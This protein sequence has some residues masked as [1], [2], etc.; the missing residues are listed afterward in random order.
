MSATFSRPLRLLSVTALSVAVTLLLPFL[1]HLI[2]SSGVPLGA[3]LLP[4]FFAPFLAAMLFH[5]AVSLITA[6]ATPALNHLLTGRPSPE[7]AGLLS[8][9]L[10]LFVGFVLLGKRLGWRTFLLAPL[11]YVGSSTL[12]YA[13]TKLFGNAEPWVSR[14]DALQIALPGLICLAILNALVLRFERPS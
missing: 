13:L 4:I 2:P 12:V 3:R 14:L 6:A 9:E 7:M 5:P 8:A 11:A 10:L 1:V